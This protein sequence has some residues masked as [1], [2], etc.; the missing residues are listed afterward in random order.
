MVNRCGVLRCNGNYNSENK[1]RVFKLPKSEADQQ[2]WIDALLHENFVIKP[3]TK[4]FYICKR[5]W[6]PGTQFVTTPGGFTRPI[7][8]P[9]IFTNVPSSCLP[10]PKPPPS[11]PKDPNKNLDVFKIKKTK[12][13]RLQNS[14]QI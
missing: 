1:V 8:P 7:D 10:T 13:F 12:F 9:S 14:H 6:P 2:C 4:T 3:K 5:H 11:R